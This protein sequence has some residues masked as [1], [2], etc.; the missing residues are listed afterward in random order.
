MEPRGIIEKKE[1]LLKIIY[2]LASEKKE[3]ELRKLINS[4]IQLDIFVGKYNPL[5]LLARDGNEEAVELLL[6]KFHGSRTQAVVG[7]ARGGQF[8]LIIKLIE[9]ADNER[10]KVDLNFT[11]L[12][13]AAEEGHE[14]LTFKLISLSPS[15]RNLSIGKALWRAAKEGHAILVNKLLAEGGKFERVIDGAKEKKI[16][17]NE[18]MLL[19]F[20]VFIED[21]K[22]RKLLVKAAAASNPTIN[23][24]SAL[25]KCEKIRQYMHDYQLN[26][27]Q[28]L[29]LASSKKQALQG[30]FENFDQLSRTFN[31]S[32][33]I[34]I[35]IASYLT[36]L[37]HNETEDLF[38]KYQTGISNKLFK[39]ALKKQG[40]ISLNFF[41][42]PANITSPY[43][44][45]NLNNFLN[46]HN[47]KA[48]AL[49][50]QLSKAKNKKEVENLLDQEK[51]QNPEFYKA[52]IEK[53]H[54]RLK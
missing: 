37:S 40:L 46:P 9:E 43:D 1:A 41:A 20:I 42:N 36:G 53:H 54:K 22:L 13:C 5:I 39:Q 21:I 3:A 15:Q 11:A 47:R 12:E 27:S 50:R 16:F 45:L 14:E 32:K 26:Y 49:L 51:E 24:K 2:R 28:T 10:E 19:N 38:K 30:W 29:A 6:K 17:L 31:L 8:D 25:T 33:D 44:F 48:E 52:V 7:A 23:A 18:A 35:H 34:F 4:G